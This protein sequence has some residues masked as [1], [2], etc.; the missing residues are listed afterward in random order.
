MEAKAEWSWGAVGSAVA[1]AAERPIAAYTRRW[2]GSMA[3]V[4]GSYEFHPV[5]DQSSE[6]DR[7][8]GVLSPSSPFRPPALPGETGGGDIAACHIQAEGELVWFENEVR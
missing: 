3:S 7:R 8:D 5:A 6:A 2:F 4:S 1:N